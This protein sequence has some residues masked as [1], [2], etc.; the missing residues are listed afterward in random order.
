MAKM[1][2]QGIRVLPFGD[3]GFAWLP[4]GTDARDLEHMVALF[5]MKPWEALRAATAYG[6]EAWAGNSGTLIGQIKPNYLADLI[7][8]DGNPLEN[9][10]LLQ[11]QNH[12]LGVMKNGEFY[13]T[14]NM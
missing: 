12:I 7:I 10:S 1:H 11:D 3:Y 8:I 4:I 13:R 2:K 14:P 5:G 9:I 6:G